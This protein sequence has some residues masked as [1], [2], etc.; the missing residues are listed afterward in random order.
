VIGVD[1]DAPEAMISEE[2]S[3]LAMERMFSRSEK[4]RPCSFCLSI[5]R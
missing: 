1:Q 4:N 5:F 2:D 3:N